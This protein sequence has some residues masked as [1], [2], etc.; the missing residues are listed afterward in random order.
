MDLAEIAQTLRSV[1]TVLEAL[2][3]PIDP[4]TLR[5]RPEETEWCPLEV[6]G[7]LIACDS[8]AFRNRIVGIVDGNPRIAGFDAWEAINGRDLAAESLDS[9]LTEL[10]QERSASCELIMSLSAADLA[11][12]AL[13]QDGRRF[14]ASDFVHEWPFHDQDHVQQILASLKVAYLPGM[15][16]AMRDAMAAG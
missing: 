14:A 9:L 5:T 1:P 4:T 12:T 13:S 16:P 10:A 8:D 6:I 7:H 11:K 2:L 15:T 3:R